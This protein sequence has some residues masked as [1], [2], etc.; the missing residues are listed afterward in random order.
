MIFGI[1]GLAVQSPETPGQIQ[2]LVTERDLIKRL[3]SVRSVNFLV[4]SMKFELEVQERSS[5]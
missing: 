4:E 5:N 3:S 1:G 2:G